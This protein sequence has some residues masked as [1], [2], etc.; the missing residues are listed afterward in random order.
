MKIKTNKKI[1]DIKKEITISEYAES[2]QF[3]PSLEVKEVEFVKKSLKD[4]GFTGKTFGELLEFFRNHPL[5]EL[6]QPEDAYYL[7]LAYTDQP[8]GEWVRLA[9]D[10]IPVL[11]GDPGVFSLG[12]G[13]GGLWLRSYWYR[14]TGEMDPDGLWFVR[15][16]VS[17][18][19]NSITQPSQSIET[20]NLE[21]AIKLVIDSGYS[22]SKN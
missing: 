6:C 11:G 20:L 17:N 3:T 14:P 13:D 22:V 10:T 16:R 4:F 2:M 18:T 19:D 5:Y 15:L 9:M 21:K 7:R 1:E 12:H 8:K